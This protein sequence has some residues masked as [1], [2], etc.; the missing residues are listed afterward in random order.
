MPDTSCQVPGLEASID[1]WCNGGRGRGAVYTL[2][3]SAGSNQR[4]ELS[5]TEGGRG[6][7]YTCTYSFLTL[8]GSD[9]TGHRS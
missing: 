3:A 6:G 4:L 5:V 9:E 2:D 8:F 7:V 1:L